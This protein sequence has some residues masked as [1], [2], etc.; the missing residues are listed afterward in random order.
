MLLISLAAILIISAV[1]SISTTNN[2]IISQ[3]NLPI[4]KIIYH[5]RGSHSFNLTCCPQEPGLLI[6]DTILKKE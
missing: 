5:F 2:S 6:K 3:D 4:R 1:N